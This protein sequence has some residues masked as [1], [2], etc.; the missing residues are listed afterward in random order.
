MISAKTARELGSKTEPERIL[1]KEKKWQEFIN[2]VEEQVNKAVKEGYMSAHIC[3]ETYFS[4]K[5]LKKYFRDLGY[6]VH[7]WNFG[8]MITLCWH[9]N[10]LKRMW[11]AFWG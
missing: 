8:E 1:E 2:H 10:R 3:R 4:K 11:Y 7:F 6:S 9:K 5:E